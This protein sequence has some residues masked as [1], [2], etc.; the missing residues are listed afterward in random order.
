MNLREVLTVC[1]FDVDVELPRFLPTL[2]AL[3]AVAG[4][5]EPDFSF[6][7]FIERDPS[8]AG[9]YFHGTNKIYLS[10]GVF[11]KVSQSERLYHITHEVIHYVDNQADLRDDEGV[12]KEKTISLLKNL[13]LPY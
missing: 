9:E 1:G 11:E 5:G 7:P 12:V 8:L 10:K 3:Y 13:G 2:N 4:V 6:L